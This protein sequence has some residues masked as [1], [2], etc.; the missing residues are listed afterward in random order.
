[1]H[2]KSLKLKKNFNVS[3]TRANF[4]ISAAVTVSA[5]M[6]IS[7]SAFV[8]IRKRRNSQEESS[9]D[10]NENNSTEL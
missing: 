8:I 4:L 9:T 10:D 6:A 3:L 7:M 5:I 1:M 2:W